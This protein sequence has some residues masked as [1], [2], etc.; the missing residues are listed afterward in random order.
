MDRKAISFLAVGFLVGMA[1]TAA[2]FSGLARSPDDG[3]GKTVLKLAHG[4]P[5]A[6]PVHRAMVRMAELA[7]EKSGGTVEI[8]IFPNGQLGSETESIE[9]LQRGALAM[10][11]TSTAAME[12][13]VP[14]MAVYGVPY[15]F[16]DEDHFWSVLEGPIGEELLEMG[17]R[18]GI[19]GLCYYDAGAR[20]FYTVRDPILRPA[21]LAGKKIRTIRSRTA[22]DMI[23]IMG[24][25]ATALGWGELYTAL[26]QGMID[27]AENNAPSV[28]DSRHWEVAKHFSLDEHTRIPDMVVFSEQVW[29]R[30]SPQVQQWVQE[31]ALE[32]VD[33][34]RQIWKEYVDECMDLLREEGV[35]VYNPDK[36]PFLEAVQPMYA[37]FNGTPVED[38]I[39]RVEEVE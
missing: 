28:Y 33:Y 1:V 16:R 25:S 22:M 12:G 31:A 4:L 18:V 27:G 35:N 20:S 7:D 32:S 23:E 29:Q 5:P 37:S 3:G 36:A 19:R 6:S 15:L 21:D 39:R 9:Q 38:L 24:G 13:F 30:L 10:V 8:Q 11:K 26:Q 17:S 14:E 2:I 34:Q